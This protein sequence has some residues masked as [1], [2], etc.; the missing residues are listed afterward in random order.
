[1]ED[2]DRSILGLA[3]PRATGSPTAGSVFVAIGARGSRV[4]DLL[5]PSSRFFEAL[6]RANWM[7]QM[8]LDLL[9]EKAQ[10][11]LLESKEYA[12]VAAPHHMLYENLM[13]L[14][15]LNKVL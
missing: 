10:L 14:Q 9:P 5:A 3:S 11:R 15:H 7:I 8:S 13:K 1:M 6:L 12:Y 4:I 2:S